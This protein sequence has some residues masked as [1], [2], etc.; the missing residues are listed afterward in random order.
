MDRVIVV[1]HAEAEGQHRD[2]PLSH[3]GLENTR[4]LV[5][6][7]NE[8]RCCEVIFSS[9]FLRAVETIKPFAEHHELPI[10]TD[11]RL[12]ERILSETPLNDWEAILEDSFEDREMKVG[13][14]ESSREAKERVSSFLDELE[15][16]SYPLIVTHGN[17]LAFI[18][19]Y[20]GKSVSFQEWKNFSYPD[21]FLLEKENGTWNFNRIW[22]N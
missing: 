1:R 9:P 16:Y 17:L 21:V 14:G 11:E 8:H 13:D 5:D 18:L 7:L 19:E 6:V 2:S 12:K 4:R 22:E 20:F 3:R 15:P 10:H